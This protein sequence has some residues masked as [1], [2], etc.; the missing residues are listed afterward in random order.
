M[1]PVLF[2]ISKVYASLALFKNYLYEKKIFSSVSLS[3]PVI[4]VGNLTLGGTGKTPLTELIIGELLKRGREPGVVVRSYRA[5]SSV[6][7]RVLPGE[8]FSASLY[9]DEAVLLA[10]RYPQVPVW[11]GPD[12]TDTAL[13]ILRAEKI[14]SV[15]LDDG[16]QHRRL[17]RKMDLLVLDATEPLH[18]YEPFPLGRA[19]EPLSSITRATA[20]VLT[21]VNLC[22]EGHLKALRT[23][24]PGNAASFEFAFKVSGVRCNTQALIDRQQPVFAACGIARP[25][26]FLKTL[27]Q[28]LGVKVSGHLAFRDHHNYSDFD[29]QKILDL[30]QGRQVVVTAKDE[31]KLRHLWPKERPLFVVDI[32]LQQTGGRGEF[33]EYITQALG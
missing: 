22:E 18:N 7:S 31:V 8:P 1:K 17:A 16:F 33:G 14:D 26:I 3:V 11:S 23:L 30:A 32:K 25:D 5:K 15:V 4:S 29:V 19:R 13:A 24:V 21:K 10:S 2:P 20:V 28:E 27:E 9:G 12:K 6:P